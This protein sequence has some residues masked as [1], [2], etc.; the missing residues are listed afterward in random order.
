[1]ELCDQI[2]ADGGTPMALGSGDAWTLTDW[3]ENIYLQQAGPEAYDTLFSAEGNWT[4]QSVKDAI[5]TMLQILTE[6]NVDGGKEGANATAFTDAIGLVFA[7]DATDYMYFE[8][9]FVGGIAVGDVNENLV[10]GETID[11]F[12]FPAIE[13]GTEGAIVIG[14][15]VIGAFTDNPGVAEFMQYMASPEGAEAWI[16]GGTIISPYAGVEPS[17]Y[18]DERNQAE[19]EHIAGAT[20]VK[21][22]GAD[23]LAAGTDLAATLSIIFTDP[24]AMDSQLETFQAEADNAWAEQE[25]G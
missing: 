10:W 5:D 24:S 13:G 18:P 14:G 7:E 20:E 2:V 22:D 6:E 4:D 9:G 16:A 15:D 8:G 3:F 19:A 23:L 25:G 1:V 12:P 11:F 17:A 21:Y